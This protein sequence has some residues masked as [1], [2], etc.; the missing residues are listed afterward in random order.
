MPSSVAWPG[1]L[2]LIN[3]VGLITMG[4]VVALHY[5]TNNTSPTPTDQYKIVPGYDA[6]RFDKITRE[7]RA[8]L[9]SFKDSL[10]ALQDQLGVVDGGL[11]KVRD[12]VDKKVVGLSEMMR[13]QDASVRVGV[14]HAILQRLGTTTPWCEDEGWVPHNYH[15]YSTLGSQ[16]MASWSNASKQCRDA[17]GHLVEILTEEDNIAVEKLTEYDVWIGAYYDD[18]GQITWTNPHAT[19][20]FMNGLSSMFIPFIIVQTMYGSEFRL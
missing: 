9:K 16:R 2:S 5:N 13:D 17:G 14:I 6:Q 20:T 12:D 18:S 8:T 4:V 10:K 19:S 3:L 7:S 1:I 11:D 15:C